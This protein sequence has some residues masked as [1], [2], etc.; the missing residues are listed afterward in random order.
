MMKRRD[1]MRNFAL[2]GL[3]SGIAEVA[4][5]LV[6]I[7][8]REQLQL[9][10]SSRSRDRDPITILR[11]SLVVDGYNGG[12]MNEAYL[13]KLKAAPVHCRVNGG[14]VMFPDE[15]VLATSVREILK[16][17]KQGKIAQVYHA[18][19]P[20]LGEKHL[21]PYGDP[22]PPLAEFYEK[23]L[24]ICG[25]CYNIANVYGGGC[26]EPHIGLTRAGR[27]LVEEVHKLRIVLDVGGHTGEQTTLD[28]IAM[29]SGVPVICTHTNVRGLNDNPRCISDRVIEAIARTGGV[30]GITTFSDFMVRN[31]KN[32]HL[33]TTPQAGLEQYLDQFDYIRKLVGVDYVGLGTDNVCDGIERACPPERQNRIVMAPEAYSEIWT[34][35]RGFESISELPNFVR[36]LI[37]RGWSTADIRKV[38]GENWLRVYEKVWGA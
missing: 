38:L 35:V 3:T 30:I 18:D 31:P 16:A 14:R 9:D 23:G 27:R 11:S 24:R 33:P 10:E 26:L 20:I 4:R 12:P 28:A 6:M 22:R 37:E 8:V 21:Q 34:Y 15:I 5:P 25:I 13:K 7:P 29:S 32:Y 2:A 1:F 17:H 36:G 19:A